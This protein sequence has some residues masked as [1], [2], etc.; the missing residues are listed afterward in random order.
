M[1]D[2][3]DIKIEVPEAVGYILE[4]LHG[5]GYEAYIV[6]GCVRDC[7]LGRAPKDWDITTS[8]LPGEVKSLFY[9]T[10]DTGLQHG[11][12]TVIR[13]GAGYEVTTYRIDGEYKDGRHPESVTFTP[14]LEEDLKRRDFTINAFA[15]SPDKGV[16][17]CFEGLKDLENG[18]IRAVGDPRKRFGEDALR[19]MRAV[20]F[21]AQL[22]F[23]IEA[24][25]KAA[26]SEFAGNLSMVSAERKRVEL[27]KTLFSANPDYVLQFKEQGL[28]KYIIP[29]FKDT[30]IGEAEEELLRKAADE[31][32]TAGQE[33]AESDKY[34]RLAVL[35]KNFGYEPCRSVMRAMTFDNKSRDMA[36]HVIKYMETDM[37]KTPEAVKLALYMIGEDVLPIVIRLKEL[38]GFTAAKE[39]GGILENV[40]E[41]GEP[42]RLS[43][44]AVNGS[45]LVAAGVKQGAGVGRRLDELLR[46]VIRKPELNDK[47][48]LIKFINEEE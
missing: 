21:S 18:V 17:D 27:E 25:T 15:Y 2:K 36:S 10:A 43:M 7:L 4:R 40:L 37:E 23:E 8:A 24:R 14:S 6:G 38:M 19:I 30:L 35:F 13:N 41:S 47:E 48:T 32:L 3:S 45:D 46:L 9:N 26:I 44:L 42:Y 33:L 22:S 11:T 5:A 34:L 1:K 12:V 16:I 20:R 39:L 29:G 31:P 28:M